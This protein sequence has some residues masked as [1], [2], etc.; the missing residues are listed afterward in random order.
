MERSLFRYILQ[1][2]WRDQILLLVVT[3]VSFPL[4]YVNLWI[5]K[6]IVNKAISGKNIPAT[7]LGF[8]VTQISY[9]M[10]L[11]LLLLTLIT[12]NGA[13]KYWLNVYRGI[14]GERTMRRLRHDLYQKVLRFPLPQFKT[15]SAGEIIPMIVSET[16]PIGNFIGESINLPV[17]QGGLLATYLVFIF[18]QNFWLGLAAVALYPPQVYLIPRLQRKIN[19]LSKERVQTARALSDR[20]GESV[21]GS[22]E[23]RGNDT[24]HLEGADISE[25]LG[26]IFGIRVEIYN[27]KF[28]VKF[29]NNFLAQVT[30]FFFYSVGGYFVIKGEL[31]L[32]ALVAVLGAYKDI[33]DP[34]KELLA[35][36]STKEDVRIKYEQIVSQF[37][38]P[39][40][41][42][43]KL[44]SDPPPAIPRLAGEIATTGLTYSEDGVINRV[45]RLSFVVSAGEHVALVGGGHCGKD[46]IAHLL[47]RLV[48]PSGGRIAVA[49][50]NFAD[51]HQAVPGRR[52]A[53]ATQNA[54]IFSG[55]LAHNLFYGLKHQPVK[56]ATYDATQAKLRH[57]RLRD[58]LAAGN[59][60]HD[61]HADW[62][63]Y[64]AAGVA[65]ANQLT[66]AALTVLRLVEMEQAVMNF[67]L[68]STSDP[69][70]DPAFAAMALE[71][72]GR[73][74]ERVQS[75][76][77]TSFVELFDRDA[78]H[79]N[80]S[81]AENLLFGTPRD[82]AF[83]PANLPT[84]PEVVELLRDVGLLDDFYAAGAA[85]AGLM[86]ELFADVPPDSPMFDQYSFISADDLP[87]FR[88]LLAKIADGNL[89]AIAD[90]EKAQLL[91]L[92]FRIVVARH[93][94]GVID[95]E[96]QRKIVEARAEFR[97]RY[98]DREDVVEFFEPG[99]FSSTLSIQDNILFGRVAFEQANAQTRVS[100]LVRDVATEVGM[101][102][103]LI[104]LGLDYE[105]GNAGS[106]LSYSERQ[107][108]A[109][110]RGVMK[111]PDV[112]VFNEPTSGLDP[113]TEVRVLRAVLGWAKG[114][115][116]VWT[117]GRA[118]L[119]REFDRV[120]VLDDGRLVEQGPFAELE[121]AGN[122]LTRLLG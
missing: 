19:L 39:G 91:A 7:F 65:D 12:L 103:A 22:A 20:I 105:V 62:I 87:E 74:R 48:F 40:L 84:N 32:G 79:S 107:R 98:T 31:S 54:H 50:A 101:N 70:A 119:A 96:R 110:A 83:Q 15:M 71:A 102:A 73:V 13:I 5:P 36:Y 52:I 24:F 43:S 27:R 86:V 67:G 85:V 28:F 37:E 95:A 92:T 57:A 33:L 30:P 42:D 78:Y 100:A 53:Y 3:A 115:T 122:A 94:L 4:I 26:T 45:E 108:L 77:L 114:R 81:V 121:H 2:T 49:G 99:R 59:S 90:E 116:V 44:I 89:D 16:E 104:R 6:E 29:L 88:V 25:R 34:W 1:H 38:P 120:I 61:I 112:L 60:P 118:D 68:A 75:E 72:R 9:L 97:R 111:N 109:I 41:I 117:L 10:T 69:H 18:N 76:N 14:V 56:A 51:V 113:A 46:D 11:S 58:A 80:I 35:W 93:R 8:D 106:R 66:E 47:T 17:F 63:D 21:A 23:I 82:R 64:E 55:T